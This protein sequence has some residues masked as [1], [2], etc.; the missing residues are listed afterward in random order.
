MAQAA[1]TRP[2]T[3]QAGTVLA[4]G[5]DLVVDSIG[6]STAAATAE[7]D[8]LY[9]G[10]LRVT[11][12]VTNR[13]SARWAAQGTLVFKMFRGR[14]EDAPTGRTVPRGRVTV[15]PKPDGSGRQFSAPFGPFTA[16]A[17]IPGSLGPGESRILT[18]VMVNP[19][20]QLNLKLVRDKYY[21]VIST[22]RA[23][24]DVDDSN[25]RSARVGRI[26]ANDRGL[27]V[28]WDPIA[29][30]P[31]SDGTVRVNAPPRP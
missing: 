31:T 26:D 14:E 13:G 23:S 17:N 20:R 22:I 1:T 18:A 4:A 24:G 2:T 16:W 8:L 9:V 15:V 27:L 19:D 25:N 6:L 29:F 5:A 11:V 30:R 10:S 28:Q 12:C 7:K 21:T 3:A